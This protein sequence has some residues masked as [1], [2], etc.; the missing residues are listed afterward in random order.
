MQMCRG[1]KTEEKLGLGWMW[2][3]ESSHSLLFLS[4]DFFFLFDL[5]LG[6]NK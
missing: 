5:L 2:G 1:V 6:L 3:G 4:K